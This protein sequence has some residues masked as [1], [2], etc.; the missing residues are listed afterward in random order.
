[1]GW[2]GV[3]YWVAVPA[4]GPHAIREASEEFR[5]PVELIIHRTTREGVC[6][7]T[8]E[9]GAGRGHASKQTALLMTVFETGPNQTED[10]S[11]K[12]VAPIFVVTFLTAFCGPSDAAPYSI[13]THYN[14][15]RIYS[16]RLYSNRLTAN[17]YYS[18]LYSN[19]LYSNRQHRH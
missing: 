7:A 9:P 1:M 5:V 18:R 13:T 4:T 6:A 16:N 2:G 8:A 3:R 12:S 10:R 14:S 19:R 11:M 17:R 15:S